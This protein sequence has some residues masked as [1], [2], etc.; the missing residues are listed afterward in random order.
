MWGLNKIA[1]GIG[2]T[3]NV[4]LNPLL[5]CVLVDLLPVLFDNYG[6]PF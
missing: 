4:E 3:D 6:L 1:P 5:F 2:Q